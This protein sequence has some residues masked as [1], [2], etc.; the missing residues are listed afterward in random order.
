M[1]KQIAIL[2]LG[3]IGASIA[4]AVRKS[5]LDARILAWDYNSESIDYGI[6]E[7]L[8]DAELKPGDLRHGLVVI[9][10][11]MSAMD[12][13]FFYLKS[14]GNYL[15]S[16]QLVITDTGSVKLPVIAIAK[17]VFGTIPPAFVPGHPIAGSE[18]SG[19]RA[20][21]E[22][23]FKNKRL[24]ITPHKNMNIVAGNEVSEFWRFIG[25]EVLTMSPEYHDQI[26]G[27]TSHLP[28]ILAY[29]LVDTLS[30]QS[31]IE[32]IWKYSAGGLRDFTRIASSDPLMW[33]DIVIANKINIKEFLDLFIDDL[34]KLREHLS[35][36][37]G[38]AL[39]AVFSNAKNMRDKALS[40]Q[41][42]P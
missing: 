38:G 41:G 4:M 21:N 33:R 26:L 16:N 37:D 12:K 3:M 20:G 17:S 32:Q 36:N 11:P 29:A 34:V 19:V 30:K 22:N 13:A 1:F 23:L 5:G 24:I 25:A 9:A 42:Q 18:L 39:E 28:H 27:M 8:I 35:N 6:K 14:M 2:G 10:V 15:D 40:K 31:D 7:D